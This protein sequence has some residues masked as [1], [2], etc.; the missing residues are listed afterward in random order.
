MRPN[1]HGFLETANNKKICHICRKAKHHEEHLFT[2]EEI[3]AIL[4]VCDEVWNA[5]AH[6]VTV[7]DNE[8]AVEV[9]L[10][11]DHPLTIAKPDPVLWKKFKSIGWENMKKL[12][13]DKRDY[14]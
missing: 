4:A 14:V 2:Y 8:A 3:Q 11:A 12:V 9:I 13:L 6:D 10:D 1:Y 7:D 5:I